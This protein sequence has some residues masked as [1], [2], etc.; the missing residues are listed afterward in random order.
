MRAYSMA[1]F[2]EENQIIMLNVRIATPPPNAPASVPP[3]VMSSFIFNLKPG[4]RVTVSGPYGEF[5]AKDNDAEMIFIGGGAGM[6]PM[7]SHIFDQLKRLHSSRKI[8]FWYGARSLR[9]S[10]YVEEF[11]LLAANHPNFSCRSRLLPSICSTLV[12]QLSTSRAKSDC[13]SR[14]EGWFCSTWESTALSSSI[15]ATTAKEGL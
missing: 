2:P 4:D 3:G 11:D 6:A 13:R 10:F 1:N 14:C 8:T 15:E 7:R 5:F 12:S 9:E